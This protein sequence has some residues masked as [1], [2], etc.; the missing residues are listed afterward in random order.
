M[1]LRSLATAY[2]AAGRK[3][4][5]RRFFEAALE[6]RNSPLGQ[7]VIHNNLG[8]LEMLDGRL[9]EAE[10]H[11]RKALELEPDA[12]D[13]LF[14]LGLVILESRGRTRA[15]AE[16]AF[17]YLSRALAI[18]PFDPDVQ[19]AVGQ[20]KALLGDMPAAIEHLQRALELG[21]NPVSAKRVE[22]LLSTLR[23]RPSS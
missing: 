20:A 4:E 21:L 9:S 18:S 2:Q 5:A 23:A 19:A 7:L 17:P 1:P 11:Y 6:R 13:A 8:T 3:D 10:Q 22:S 15:A 12:P 14:N 16:Q